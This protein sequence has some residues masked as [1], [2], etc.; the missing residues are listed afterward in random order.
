MSWGFI[1]FLPSLAILWKQRL[2]E[3]H[4]VA[5]CSIALLGKNKKAA[6]SSFFAGLTKGFPSELTPLRLR[7]KGDQ[8]TPGLGNKRGEVP[9][10]WLNL[11]HLKQPCSER[12]THETQD[13]KGA[14]SSFTQREPL[15]N[16]W[17]WGGV[18]IGGGHPSSHH[19]V[20]TRE[21]KSQ[22]LKNKNS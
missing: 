3:V 22:C 5:L 14:G 17:E 10:A 13:P 9:G 7:G 8:G 21:R 19:H 11:S 16:G 6:F 1:P 12:W 20:H 18:V 15:L 4:I 2:S